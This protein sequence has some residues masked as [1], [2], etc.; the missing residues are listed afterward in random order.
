MDF[1]RSKWSRVDFFQFRIEH[2]CPVTSE[3]YLEGVRME[4]VGNPFTHTYAFNIN[5][6]FGVS[7]RFIV[8]NIRVG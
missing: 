3:L 8:L 1:V 2:Q 7:N 4:F 5:S 6:D